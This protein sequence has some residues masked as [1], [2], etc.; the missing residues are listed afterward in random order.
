MWGNDYY[1]GNVH[2]NHLFFRIDATEVSSLARMVNDLPERSS[3]CAMK[4]VVTDNEAHL[5]LFSI[6]DIKCGE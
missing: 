6:K 5:L 4:K 1:I 2:V 3:N